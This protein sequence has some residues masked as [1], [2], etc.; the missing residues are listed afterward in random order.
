VLDF[1]RLEEGR[2]EY[3]MATVDTTSWVTSAASAAARAL[4]G[5]R[6]E[7]SIPADL[8]PIVGD[9]E[10]PA[11]AVHNLID[12]AAKYSPGRDAVWL[13]A[14][15]PPDGVAICVRDQGIGIAPADQPHL[16]DRFY[17]GAEMANAVKGTGLGLSL[18]KH[19]IDAHQRR[20]RI[21]SVQ[22]EGTTVTL[23]LPTSGL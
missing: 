14:L 21:D 20:V 12:N 8:P 22:G 17:R 15:A 9:G 5:K 11:T 1:S 3:A 16:F 6:L 4:G 23:E 10:A 7:A 19:I 18:V 13:T 2:R